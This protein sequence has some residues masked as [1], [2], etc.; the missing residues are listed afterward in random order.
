MDRDEERGLWWDSTTCPS[1][2]RETCRIS[3]TRGPAF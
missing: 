2:G 1:L 3:D